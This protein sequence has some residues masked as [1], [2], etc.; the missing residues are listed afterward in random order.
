MTGSSLNNNLNN[1]IS[2]NL[3]NNISN[4]L[5]DSINNSIELAKIWNPFA[6]PVPLPLLPTIPL[7]SMNMSNLNF[8]TFMPSLPPPLPD[9][10]FLDPNLLTVP[11]LPE[12]AK[13][14]II[15]YLVKLCQMQQTQIQN[16]QTNLDLI[17]KP[18]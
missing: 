2:N 11:A 3:N 16:L 1:A 5:S 9:P 13:D 18:M 8:N 17:S 6:N 14:S 12:E 15:A 4:N 10:S 7:P